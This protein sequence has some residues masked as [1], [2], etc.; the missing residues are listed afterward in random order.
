MD[1]L[2]A[3]ELIYEQAESFAKVAVDAHRVVES[4]DGPLS[5]EDRRFKWMALPTEAASDLGASIDSDSARHRRHTRSKSVYDTT[6]YRRSM[7]VSAH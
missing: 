2:K 4:S 5:D 7:S 1:Y 3:A 6:R